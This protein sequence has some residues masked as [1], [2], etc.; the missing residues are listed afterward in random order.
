MDYKIPKYFSQ[1]HEEK[2][3]YKCGSMFMN[4][5]KTISFCVDGVR[6]ENYLMTF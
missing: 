3:G 4:W 2:L 6:I 5:G 1:H